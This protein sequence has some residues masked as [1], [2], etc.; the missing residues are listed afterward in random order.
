MINTTLS[1]HRLHVA[2]GV[3]YQGSINSYNNTVTKSFSKLL[4]ISSKININ[5][6]TRYLNKKSYQKF[7]ITLDIHPSTTFSITNFDTLPCS[8]QESSKLMRNYICS[9]KSNKLGEQ[10]IRA[11]LANN[12]DK[13]TELVGKGA[14]IDK[15]FWLRMPYGL[16]FKDVTHGLPYRNLPPIIALKMTPFHYAVQDKNDQLK[17]LLEEYRANV[18]LEGEGWEFERQISNDTYRVNNQSY[19]VGQDYYRKGTKI[20]YNSSTKTLDLK[21]GHPDRINNLKIYL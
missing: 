19:L 17:Q 4:G 11:I 20:S 10:F 8:F 6:Q 5:N 3:H 2:N 12:M 16:T 21:P 15:L 18:N 7:L 1:N 13:A 14:Q 9:K